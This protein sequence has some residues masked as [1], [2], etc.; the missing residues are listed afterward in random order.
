MQRLN[1]QKHDAAQT[2]ARASRHRQFNKPPTLTPSPVSCRTGTMNCWH[3]H[4]RVI[5]IMFNTGH[6]LLLPGGRLSRPRMVRD[7][8][9]QQPR[10]I[11]GTQPRPQPIHDLE[12]V[13]VRAQSRTIHGPE[14]DAIASSPR[15]QTRPRAV[16]EHEQAADE[17]SRGQ[18]TATVFAGPR[19]VRKFGN[20]TTTGRLLTKIGGG[21]HTAKAQLSHSIRVSVSPPT[22]FHIHIK[23]AP[24]YGLI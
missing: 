14:W 8:D 5:L 17:S 3:K 20:S 19:P 22:A 9:A 13:S 6:A 10:K 18:A 24:T 1:R 4:R 16:R 11:G 23:L 7:V 15:S 21:L 2:T 12:S